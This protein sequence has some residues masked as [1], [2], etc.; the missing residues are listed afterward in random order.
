V[1]AVIALLNKEIASS[2]QT[3]WNGVSRWWAV[4]PI[5]LLVLYRLLRR[6]YDNYETLRTKE[7][8][9]QKTIETLLSGPEYVGHFYQFIPFPRTGAAKEVIDEIFEQRAREYKCDLDIFVEVYLVNKSPKT[10]N[11]IEYRLEVID[12]EGLLRK[13]KHDPSFAGWTLETKTSLMNT[14]TVP[15]VEYEVSETKIPSLALMIS[16]RNNLQQGEG[17]EGWLH[18]VMENVS[19]GETVL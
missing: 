2:L 1:V 17:L 16:E 19:R 5:A 9:L 6:N 4:A 18:F 3:Q 13:A 10:G 15:L 7:H 11:I 14:T 8:Q 12:Q